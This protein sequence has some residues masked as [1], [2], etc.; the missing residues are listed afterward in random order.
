MHLCTAAEIGRNLKV[1]ARTVHNLAY[2]GEIPTALRRGRI[3]RFDKREVFK[4]LGL[5]PYAGDR[6]VR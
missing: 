5:G 3:V 4:A 1:T 2:S 6:G